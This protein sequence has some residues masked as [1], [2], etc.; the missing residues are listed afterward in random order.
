MAATQT[1]WKLDSLAIP[2]EARRTPIIAARNVPYT[3][4]ANERQ[5]LNVYLPRTAQ[6]L[7]LVEKPFNTLPHVQNEE[8]LPRWHVHIHGGAWRDPLL[9]SRSIETEAAIAF[10][11]ESRLI[12]GIISIDY[13]LSPFPTHPSLPY[14]MTKGDRDDPSREARHPQ[15]VSDVLNAFRLLRS[16]GLNDGSYILT[17]HSAG[18]CLAFQSHLMLPDHWGVALPR[19]PRP[20]ALVGLNGLYDLP[21][22]VYRLGDSHEHLSE[23]YKDLLA[24]AF[25]SDEIQWSI[26]SPARLDTKQLDEKICKGEAPPLVLIDQSTEDQL[27]PTNQADTMESKLRQVRGLKVVRGQR[28]KGAHAAPWEGGQIIWDTLKD[29]F[30]LLTGTG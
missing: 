11:D 30:A 9:R 5:N 22:L 27:V 13:T 2:H 3:V 21:D 18:A 6:S 23:V 10:S 8:A 19:P 4:E 16:L 12:D 26:A 24:Q 1:V 20:A 17:G 29:V 7:H 14:D 15:H 25:G 28:C